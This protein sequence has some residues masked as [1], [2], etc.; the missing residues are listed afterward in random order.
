MKRFTKALSMLLAIVMVVGLLPLSIIAEDIQNTHTVEFKLNYNGAHKIPSQKVADG[1]CAVQPEDVTRTGWIFEY[2]YVKTGDGIQKFDLSQPIT[3][4][5]TLYARW[6]EDITYWGPIWNRNILNGIANSEKEDVTEEPDDDSAP[7][8]IIETSARYS[9]IP[10]IVAS[11]AQTDDLICLT[12]SCTD[13]SELYDIYLS[14]DGVTFASVAQT[15]EVSYDI[16]AENYNE[17][18]E[19]Y[20]KVVQT[21]GSETVESNVVVMNW[22]EGIF[23]KV[24]EDTDS[25][26]LEDYIEDLFG[27][28]N[29]LDDSDD[30]GINDY[31]EIWKIGTEPL[32]PDSDFDSTLDGDEDFDE[33][34]LTT[35]DELSIGTDPFNLDSDYDEFSDYDEIKEYGTNPTSSDT[36][37][38]GLSDSFE[39]TLGTDPLDSDSNDNGIIDGQENYEFNV[40]IAEYD[41]NTIPELEIEAAG[42]SLNSLCIEPTDP[43]DVITSKNIPGFIGNGY[44]ITMDGTFKRAKLSI[45][46]EQSLLSDPNFDPVIYYINEETQEME[47]LDTVVSG[48]TAYAELKHFSK[49]IL[50]NRYEFNKSLTWI[51]WWEEEKIYNGVEIVLVIDD[52]GSMDSNDRYNQRLT[53]AKN[54]IDSL[55]NNSKIGI[56][57]F[58]SDVELLTTTLTEDRES[59]KAYLT[60]GYFKSNGGT[61]MYTAIGNAFTLFESTDEKILKMMVVLSDGNTS[62]TSKHSSVISTA[63]TNDVKIYTIGLGSS[64]RYFNSYLKPLA[65]NTGGNFYLAQNASSLEEIYTNIGNKIDINTDSDM[66]GIS[67]YYEE[68]MVLFNR[69]AI[70]L[71]KNDPDSD[72]DRLKDGEEIKITYTYNEDRSKVCV[73]GKLIS[74]PTKMDSDGDEIEDCFDESPMKPWKPTTSLGNIVKNA[75]FLYY[76]GENILYS[77]KKAE[78]SKMGFS[79]AYDE[80]IFA[81]LS[82]LDCEPVYFLYEGKEWMIELWKGQYG[83]ETGAEIGVYNRD[84]ATTTLAN[85]VK[86]NLADILAGLIMDVVRNFYPEVPEQVKDCISEA[87]QDVVSV[88]DLIKQL[89]DIRS[90]I[91]DSKIWGLA[92]FVNF[93]TKEIR[94]TMNDVLSSAASI[95]SSKLYN[96]VD[97][98]EYLEMSFDLYKNGTKLFSRD[99]L[100]HWWLT[101]FEWG[102]F[103]G[104]PT[105]DLS[106]AVNITFKDAA[107]KQAFLN[108]S[109]AND[110]SSY[111]EFIAVPTNYS[112]RNN[113]N[114]GNYGLLNIGN[115][116][117]YTVTENGNTVSFVFAIPKSAQPLT[118]VVFKNTLYDLNNEVVKTYNSFKKVLG[119][120]SN[121]PNVIERET[122][123]LLADKDFI[124]AQVYQIFYSCFEDEFETYFDKFLFDVTFGA[125]YK[126]E[127]ADD[128][129]VF[130]QDTYDNLMETI[131]TVVRGA[132]SIAVAVVGE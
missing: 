111:S 56:V 102:V 54:L 7:S 117:S 122:K 80:G 72:D 42:T 84:S 55:P 36:D 25:D 96:C 77:R 30:D 34:G 112:D 123:R 27:T 48:N 13:Q 59:A 10:V 130:L 12:W 101:G 5:V 70:E 6:D 71:D 125:V 114:D 82:I 106:M 33:D 23:E 58:E 81:I 95:L 92:E 22:S 21:I 116:S 28:A 4:D 68:N 53:V 29:Y 38:D 2:W 16:V 75:G 41:E 24:V 32:L 11:A 100:G 97:S 50:V 91:L 132:L 74:N 93:D 63:T 35:K 85:R 121:D 76:E 62:D 120:N 113:D 109:A 90:S 103:T 17:A 43:E 45:T 61:M 9:K 66:D 26:G 65:E 52:S 83:V 8:E 107:M 31:D 126:E 104:N 98:D 37:N 51:D 87:L 115:K 19:I 64:T 88:D 131:N 99:T 49:Y 47:E 105:Y 78:Q 40:P 128:I 67:D 119:I 69:I 129:I 89:E 18:N 57:N 118:Q 15:S 39:V 94:S 73:T 108:G 20:L 14:T 44:D 3:E 110:S 1:E 60:T 127:Y 79:Y 46:F 124:N 86:G